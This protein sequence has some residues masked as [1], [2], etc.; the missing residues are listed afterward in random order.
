MYPLLVMVSGA[1]SGPFVLDP[2]FTALPGHYQVRLPVLV[3]LF[4]VEDLIAFRMRF[5]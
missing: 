5:I 4:Q 1:G 3:Q 2:L